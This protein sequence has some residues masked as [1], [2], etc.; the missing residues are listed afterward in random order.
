MTNREWQT[1]EFGKLVKAAIGS[2]AGLEGLKVNE[3]ETYIAKQINKEPSTIRKYK[4]EVFPP[5][6]DTIRFLAEFGVKKGYL[7]Q[8][9][10][11][12]FL[13][14]SQHPDA[15]EITNNLFPKNPKTLQ[16]HLSRLDNLPAPPFI[17]Y[18]PRH[19]SEKKIIEALAK[20][21]ALVMLVGSAGA[22]KSSL[23]FQIAQQSL[24][25]QF[26]NGDYQAVV[27]VDV[28]GRQGGLTLDGVWDTIARTLNDFAVTG[29]N[30]EVKRWRIDQMLRS[31]RIL[32]VLDSIDTLIS[33]ITEPGVIDLLVWLQSIPEPSKA[34]VTCRPYF[35]QDKADIYWNSTSIVPLE[36]MSD[37][38][39]EIFIQHLC[40]PGDIKSIFPE[41]KFLVQFLKATGGNA[42]AIELAF[43]YVRYGG[44]KLEDVIAELLDGTSRIFDLL[45]NN[46]WESQVG[47]Y[48]RKV[49]MAMVPFHRSADP[50]GLQSVSGL[51]KPDFDHALESLQAR[52]LLSRVPQ[53]VNHQTY[54]RI[55]IHP[56]ARAYARGHW[57]RSSTFY[58][59]SLERWLQWYLDL[60]KP[61]GSCWDDVKRLERLDVESDHIIS[62]M[63]WALEH[64]KYDE[65]VQL[66]RGT[67]Y[68]YYVRGLLDRRLTVDKLHL[69]AARQSSDIKEEIKA[70][71]YH[72]LIAGR[73][74]GENLV[75]Q[76]YA[77]LEYCVSRIGKL[78]DSLLG[79]YWQAGAMYHMN[80]DDF[81]KSIELWGK[82]LY[83]H[84]IRMVVGA[85]HWIA[86]C[87]FLLNNLDEARTILETSLP[88][89]KGEGFTRATLIHHLLLARIA[90]RQGRFDDARILLEIGEAQAAN[91][92]CPIERAEVNFV[93][94]SLYLKEEKKQEAIEELRE[95]CNRFERMK[96]KE[97][98]EAKDLL[99]TLDFPEMTTV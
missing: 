95:A 25:P 35:M 7:N 17:E 11:D 43:G 60:V 3:V 53:T 84:D 31:Q 58:Q 87:Y 98:T 54:S 76:Y 10:L 50:Q 2:M 24:K 22:G 89:V 34:L 72:I 37:E 33:R 79:L 77:E 78:S 46:A 12:R 59:S 88:I 47:D 66:A 39:A 62:V 27:W 6:W 97:L 74:D 30:T 82:T 15:G 4:G 92:T 41:E 52:A 23:V 21:S 80:L 8:R 68:Y 18:V 61:I 45:F 99:D 91:L 51:E 28:V 20:R 32:V 69:E 48:G 71:A 40:H 94:G 16:S 42:K 36:E 56:L 65:V 81:Q 70:L 86:R 96:M 19:K 73:Q 38:E 14:V 57:E 55:M 85:R 63:R 64:R 93:R 67:R 75:S 5:D 9:W 83:H 1:S 49:W 26:P 13:K 29:E 90:I 44:R